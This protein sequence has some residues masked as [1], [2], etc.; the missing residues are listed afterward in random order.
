MYCSKANDIAQFLLA[1]LALFYG[2]GSEALGDDDSVQPLNNNKQ[3]CNGVVIVFENVTEE[4]IR[5]SAIQRY[6]KR[7]NEMER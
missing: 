2:A 7:L 6:Q 5:Q 3:K 1:S 4:R